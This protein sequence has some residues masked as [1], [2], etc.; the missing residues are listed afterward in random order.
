M[1]SSQ[2]FS[3]E[4]PS[5]RNLEHIIGTKVRERRNEASIANAT[6]IASGRNKNPPMPG[7]KAN[8]AR[9]I[10]VVQVATKT[11]RI[12]SPQPSSAARMRDFPMSRCRWLFSSSTMAS[13]T[14]GPMARASPLRVIMFSVFPVQKRPVT[15]PRRARGME[16]VAMNVIRQFPRNPRII[17][18]TSAAPRTPSKTSAFRD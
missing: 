18:D 6:A 7:R 14:N 12:T 3:L 15:A 8:G 1:P 9:T 11:G 2:G 16:S 4:C 10:I 5:G 13:S 17:R